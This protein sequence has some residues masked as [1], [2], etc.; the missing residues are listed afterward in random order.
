[1]A[2]PV[3]LRF[4][5]C[6]D[7]LLTPAGH[8]ISHLHSVSRL[9]RHVQHLSPPLPRSLLLP[10]LPHSSPL[11]PMHDKFLRHRRRRS[12]YDFSHS[13]GKTAATGDNHPSISEGPTSFAD[14][15]GN[16]PCLSR[17]KT[18]S[19]ASTSKGDS[20]LGFCVCAQLTYSLNRQ[21]LF[22]TT[23]DLRKW[24]FVSFASTGL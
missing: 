14:S 6:S 1:M 24:S 17:Y 15:S 10:T 16:Q 9:A 13:D 21:R 7:F 23:I 4:Y 8:T 22:P 11:Q 2:I 19:L 12:K 3:L 18:E 5:H 20:P